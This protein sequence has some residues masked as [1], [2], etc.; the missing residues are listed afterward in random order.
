MEVTGGRPGNPGANG[1]MNPFESGDGFRDE[2]A[3][4]LQDLVL[5]KGL[6]MTLI[7]VQLGVSAFRTWLILTGHAELHVRMAYGTPDEQKNELET[8]RSASSI[9][10]DAFALFTLRLINHLDLLKKLFVKVFVHSAIFEAVVDDITDVEYEDA[11]ILGGR[12]WL[13]GGGSNAG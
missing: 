1:R 2:H 5:D 11:I 7:G 10:V 4:K 3:Q 8:A 13:N 12:V 6:P 9:C